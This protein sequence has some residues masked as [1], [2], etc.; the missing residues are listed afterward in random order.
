MSTV[1]YIVLIL[2]ASI[3]SA[4]ALSL[5]LIAE[6]TEV[7]EASVTGCARVVH[8]R[9]EAIS[10]PPRRESRFRVDASSSGAYGEPD[11]ACDESTDRIIGGSCVTVTLGWNTW[12]ELSNA[13]L[14]PSAI[15]AYIV[16]A[17]EVEVH[18]AVGRDNWPVAPILT[19]PGQIRTCLDGGEYRLIVRACLY[20]GVP[21]TYQNRPTSCEGAVVYDINSD[22]GGFTPPIYGTQTS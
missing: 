6:R 18:G 5:A 10:S 21:P 3:T 11:V 16:R 9:N 14:Y 12:S 22:D 7:D 17:D 19:E 2:A 4:N 13:P 8:Y 15:T 1:A 20:N